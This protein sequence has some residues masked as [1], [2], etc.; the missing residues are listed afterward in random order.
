MAYTIKRTNL[1]D[2][3]TIQDGTLNS[4]ATSLSLPGRN[5]AGY[6]NVI[7]T[8]FVRLL[9][10]F[11]SA[12]PPANPIKGQLW[13]DTNNSK[14]KVCPADN[15]TDPTAWAVLTTGTSQGDSGA[16]NF[17]VGNALVANTITCN[18]ATV[19]HDILVNGNATISGNIVASLANVAVANIGTTRTRAIT[20]G[21]AGTTGT[22]EGSWTISATGNAFNLTSG[23]IAMG[24]SQVIMCDH[25][26]DTSGNPWVPSGTYVNANVA[27]FLTGSNPSVARF[28]GNIAPNAI[29]TTTL[30]T[31]ANTIVGNITGNWSL[32]A[33]SK[34]LATYSAD[35]AERYA[36]DSVY[37]VGTVVEL[38]GD[39]EVTLAKTDLSSEIF[40]VVS[41]TYAHLLN[42]A[43]GTD[44]TH[45]PIALTGRV[46]V[47]VVGPVAKGQRLVSA[48]NGLARAGKLEELTAFNVVG[49]SLVNKTDDGEGIIEAAV[50]IK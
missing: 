1:T 14:L 15:T 3:T 6:G 38:G 33:G 25:Y 16:T 45:P 18:S 50:S 32:T 11:A 27:E 34:L 47:R 22:I 28:T 41:N 37:T 44:E 24:S 12:N 9:E 35:I 13:Y 4:T 29:Q 48:G 10:N 26:Y 5:Y 7:D 43:A 42:S 36:A 20:T 23:N 31:G 30:T 40:G 2:L 21:G 8:N 46:A 19:A 39:Y 17:T 49:R